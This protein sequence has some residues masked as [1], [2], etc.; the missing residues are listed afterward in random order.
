MLTRQARFSTVGPARWLVLG[1]LVYVPFLL[2]PGLFWDDWAWRWVVT[3][4][5]FAALFRDTWQMSHPGYWPAM[6]LF[7]SFDNAGLLA[8]AVGVCCHLA[9]VV[10]LYRILRRPTLTRPAAIATAIIYLMSPWYVARAL[11]VQCLYDIFLL[12]YLLSIWWTPRRPAG[13]IVTV[14]SLAA[15]IV[16]LSLETLICLEGLRWMYARTGDSPAARRLATRRCLAFWGGALLFTVVRLIWLRPSGA[17]AGYNELHLTPGSVAHALG[18]ALFFYVYAVYWTIK[19]GAA[20][21]SPAGLAGLVLTVVLFVA[22][23]VTSSGHAPDLARRRRQAGRI[24][25]WGAAL[26]AVGALPYVLAGR[27]PSPDFGSRLAFVSI[28]G[29]CLAIGGALS[30]IGARRQWVSALAAMVVVLAAASLQTTKWYL[31]DGLVQRDLV[32]AVGQAV[33]G[34]SLPGRFVLRMHPASKDVLVFHRTL[35]GEDLNVPLNLARGS[36]GLVFVYDEAWAAT[37]QVL[38]AGC[39]ITTLDSFPCPP[40]IATLDYTLAPG[41]RSVN[42]V[43]FVRLVRMRFASDVTM[44]TVVVTPTSGELAR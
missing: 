14:R 5:G 8:R 41:L 27:A 29:V 12:C 20:L 13:R 39:T 18:G 26:A 3:R 7:Y 28:P 19:Q 40:T 35:A 9:N 32:R 15:F 38:A 22:W 44:G 34:S 10:L 6:A 37:A 11:L 16:G 1:A 2:I 17:Y 23:A 36:G 21:V 24:V 31:Y 25:L 33:A 30:A 43:S 42:D 4:E